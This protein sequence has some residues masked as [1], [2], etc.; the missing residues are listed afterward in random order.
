MTLNRMEQIK[1]F[2]H[3][4]PPE[5]KPTEPCKEPEP[6]CK[7]LMT[8]S[9]DSSTSNSEPSKSCKEFEINHGPRTYFDKVQPL[10]RHVQ[11][12]AKKYYVPST[13]IAR[14]ADAIQTHFK[15]NISELT[16][17]VK[18]VNTVWAASEEGQCVLTDIDD[19]GASKSKTHDTV[20]LFWILNSHL[21]TNKRMS[22]M[23]EGGYTDK[24]FNITEEHLMTLLMRPQTGTKELVQSINQTEALIYVKE[25]PGEF[26]HRLFF[27]TFLDHDGN[28]C[29]LNPSANARSGHNLF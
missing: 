25:H 29:L 4:S 18:E 17:R 9:N 7:E 19:Q 27:T 16:E 14:F 28:T 20:S 11:E 3:V 23:P 10:L 22:F 2:L 24:F 1:R 13:N 8:T 21:P 15:R 5:V 26:F 12:T 6:R